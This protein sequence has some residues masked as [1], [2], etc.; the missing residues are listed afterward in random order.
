MSYGEAG[1]EATGIF[2]INPNFYSDE[3]FMSDEVLQ[4]EPSVARNLADLISESTSA[5]AGDS[6]SSLTAS[7]EPELN[8]PF[9]N[10]QS[11]TYSKFQ[12]MAD[13]K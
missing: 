12:L 4:L 9:P 5:G 13:G 1:F 2:P 3:D 7:F 8:I 11:G 6:V 10:L